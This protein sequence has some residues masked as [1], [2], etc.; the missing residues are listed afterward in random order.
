MRKRLA[1]HQQSAE[2][3][4]CGIEVFPVAGFP[5]AIDFCRLA[6]WKELIKKVRLQRFSPEL[7][8]EV[9]RFM[10][11]YKYVEDVVNFAAADYWATPQEFLN[12]SGDC[13]DYAIAKYYTLRALGMETASL[14]IVAV[15][16]LN[17]NVGHAILAVYLDGQSY[18]L[19]NQFDGV[20]TADRIKHYQAVYSIN[21]EQWWKH[22]KV[23]P[24]GALTR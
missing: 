8:G 16:D 9:N 12:F 1:R 10:N 17:L 6:D 22:I 23:A 7:L 3:I 14:R 24:S 13:E 18:I 20:V 11:R 2:K 21:E 4:P 5:K 19:D 15:L